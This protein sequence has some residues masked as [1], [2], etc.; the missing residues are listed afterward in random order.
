MPN[1]YTLFGELKVETAGFKNSLREAEARLKATAQA[2]DNTEAKARK[3]GQTSATAGRGFDRMR[4]QVQA[5]RTQLGLMAQ[6]FERGDVSGKKL[7]STLQQT[8]RTTNTLGGRLR[9]STARLQDLANSSRT[10]EGALTSFANKMGR[11]AIVAGPLAAGTLIKWA[12]G[13]D[14]IRNRLQAA[15]GSIDG[16]NRKFKELQTL[17]QN[18]PGVLVSS[19]VELYAF[20]KPMKLGEDTINDLIKALGRLKMAND[21]IDLKTFGMNLTQLYTQAFEAIDLKELVGRFKEGG[22]ILQK[23]FDLSASD[24]DTIAKEMKDKLAKGLSKEQF[25]A[26]IAK[27][28]ESDPSLSKLQETMGGK[29]EK[30]YDRIKIAVEPAGRGLADA[31]IAPFTH[32]V[33]SLERIFG[34]ATTTDSI[35]VFF[36]EL[37]AAIVQGAL[38]M[39]QYAG[40]QTHKA[41]SYLLESLNIRSAA[42]SQKVLDNFNQFFADINGTIEQEVTQNAEKVRE[43]SRKSLQ[44]IADDPKQSDQAREFARKRLAFITEGLQATTQGI[45][46]QIPQIQASLQRVGDAMN[47]TVAAPTKLAAQGSS[48]GKMFGVSLIGSTVAALAG[49]GPVLGGLIAGATAF[50]QSR[51]F[52]LAQQ[53]GRSLGQGLIAGINAMRGPVSFAAGGLMGLVIDTTSEKAERKSPSRVFMR[54]G[55]DLGRGLIIG[56][57]NSTAPVRAAAKNL[58]DTVIKEFKDLAKQ[59]KD[60]AQEAATILTNFAQYANL[61]NA[62]AAAQATKQAFEDLIKLRR[63][64]GITGTAPKTAEDAKSELGTL[65]KLK[66]LIESASTAVADFI[67]QKT[68]LFDL[69]ALFSDAKTTKL[70]EDRAKALGMTVAQF[71]LMLE[72]AAQ[73]EQLEKANETLKKFG[74][75]PNQQRGN[76]EPGNGLDVMTGISNPSGNTIDGA[77]K[78]ESW[79]D[80]FFKNLEKMRKSLPTIKQAIKENLLDAF[81][82][83]GD[84]FAN[85]VSQWDGTA[86]GFFKSLAQ[87]FRALAQDIISQLIRIAVMRAVLQIAGMFAG[88]GGGGDVAGP[89]TGNI[90][91]PG[92]FADGGFTGFG[93]KDSIA[94]LVHRGEYVMPQS[95]VKR[96]GIGFMDALKQG[97]A[98]PMPAYAGGNA[99]AT[100][101][102]SQSHTFNINV[103]GGGSATERKASAEAVAR[104]VRKALL[105]DQYRNR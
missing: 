84:V 78:P 103:N 8:E 42:D 54:I 19:A 49:F 48:V 38:A 63:E 26:A 31:V 57:D 6:G 74:E 99:G 34:Q 65:E 14:S 22:E 1:A 69:M 67:K 60:A 70:I 45:E 82:R 52:G 58:A 62:L 86:R 90:G 101:N 23:A 32:I 17:A 83:I 102:N 44:K 89:A 77:V 55:Q 7:A 4:E 9:D 12:A 64:F 85:A 18:A 61:Q 104:E 56:I 91:T 75:L 46:K 72:L 71:R 47:T 50:A 79:W 41:M 27:A 28:I 105:K 15:T 21:E 51:A 97:F 29:F 73:S 53:V 92:G 11:L 5:S 76:G 35:N 81:S 96:F 16:A 10:T 39:V 68:S 20:F 40:Q 25:F 30:L 2:I 3:L 13:I 98:P 87:G 88:A 43:A 33:E 36:V 94:G 100:Y 66:T 80:S 37:G 93:A 95:V 59:S 24:L